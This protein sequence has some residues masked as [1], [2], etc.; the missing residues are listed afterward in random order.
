MRSTGASIIYNFGVA[1][2]GGLSPL[3]TGSLVKATGNNF[4]PFYYL[5]GCLVLSLIGLLLLPQQSRTDMM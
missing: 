4:A 1:I 3:I 5:G 2:F